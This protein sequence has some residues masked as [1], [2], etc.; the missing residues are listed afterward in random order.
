[1]KKSY[2]KQMLSRDKNYRSAFVLAVA[3][4]VVCAAAAALVLWGRES[5]SIFF[6]PCRINQLTGYN[7]LSCG[8][9]R[10][11]LA[12]I[13]G[14]IARAFYYNPLYVVFLCWS[15]YL[16]IRLVVSLIIKPYRRYALQLNWKW[17]AAVAAII[18]AF[19]IIRN[20]P[21]YQAVFY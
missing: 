5:L 2:L 20:M 6:M 19:T 1:M 10:S 4:P 3:V 15:V 17:A 7:C 21:F 16:Y 13:D 9:T 18:V 11:T 8:A 12:L 14:D